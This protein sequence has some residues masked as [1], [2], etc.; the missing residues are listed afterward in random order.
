MATKT[1]P[2]AVVLL[3]CMA[4][5]SHGQ[6]VL[7]V[8]YVDVW[9]EP[10]GAEAQTTTGDFYIAADGRQRHD[11]NLPTGELVSEITLPDHQRITFNRTARTALRGSAA[12]SLPIPTLESQPRSLLPTPDRGRLRRLPPDRGRLRRLHDALSAGIAALLPGESTETNGI[13]V[14]QPERLGI[15]T[16]WGVPLEGQRLN[17]P[18]RGGR[19]AQ[20]VTR[21]LYVSEDRTVRIEVEESVTM[22]PEDGAPWLAREK[23]ATDIRHV[24]DTG[25]LFT[26]PADARTMKWSR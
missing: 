4:T 7:Q 13:L 9:Y 21:W 10:D 3:L 24:P 20:E 19:P 14:L 11:W 15:Q 22:M 17:L 6:T 5:V 23:R 16:R 25:D 1:T 12:D 18:P 26:V 2:A 8:S